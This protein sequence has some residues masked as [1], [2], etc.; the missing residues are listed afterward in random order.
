MK[1]PTSSEV[2]AAAQVLRRF[3]EYLDQQAVAQV[4]PLPSTDTR[5]R[6]CDAVESRLLAQMQTVD[7]S[8]AKLVPAARKHKDR[9]DSS[10]S[11]RR[12]TGS[13]DPPY[14]L[15]ADGSR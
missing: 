6:R 2:L 4:K 8:L 12:R 9:H 10:H 3:N 1:N 14:P 15:H 5:V 11:D 13:D 7:D